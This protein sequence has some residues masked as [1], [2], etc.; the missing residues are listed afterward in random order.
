MQGLRASSKAGGGESII[1][2]S[3]N[4][5]PYGG[6]NGRIGLGGL[7]PVALLRG[8]PFFV[9]VLAD[10]SNSRSAV[11]FDE[12]SDGFERLACTLVPKSHYFEES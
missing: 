4:F 10:G 9:T 5:S 2:R 8:T 6:V 1:H 3:F 7:P 11:A 12:S